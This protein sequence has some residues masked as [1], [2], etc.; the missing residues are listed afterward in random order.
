M[1]LKKN[2]FSQLGMSLVEMTIAMALVGA[3]ALGLAQL[4]D[5]IAT[6][7]KKQD[8]LIARSQFISALNT[9]LLTPL[10]CQDMRSLGTSFPLTPNSPL[11]LRFTRWNYLGA[12]VIQ[13]GTKF[14]YFNLKEINGYIDNYTGVTPIQ[15]LVPG[16]GGAEENLY[17]TN[18]NVVALVEV[19]QMTMRHT[20]NVPV[21]VNSAN[22]LRTCAGENDVAEGCS[23]Q[24]GVY[25]S[26]TMT[27][28]LE[29]GCFLQGTYTTL[30]CSPSCYPKSSRLGAA[31]VNQYTGGYSCPAGSTAVQ[32]HATTWTHE[33]RTGKKSTMTV[34]NNKVWFSCMSCPSP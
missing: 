16:G 4:W 22:L 30:T 19:G 13:A 15:A 11:A 3:G 33:E 21:F 14:K 34:R 9:Y 25:N 17:K 7:A 23:S 6:G 2:L 27:C 29:D 20:L 32:T 24:R 8:S 26:E 12:P 28:E 10:A 1:F 31:Q 5:N 18:L